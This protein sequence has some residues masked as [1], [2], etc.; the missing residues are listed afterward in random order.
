VDLADQL[1]ALRD[2]DAARIRVPA[3]KLM[4]SPSRRASNLNAIKLPIQAGAGRLLVDRHRETLS[5]VHRM[6]LFA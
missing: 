2:Y 5:S 6:I 1:A 4:G 3:A